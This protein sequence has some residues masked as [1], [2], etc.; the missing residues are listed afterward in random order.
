MSYNS[1]NIGCID[2]FSN[3]KTPTHESK[4]ACEKKKIICA[5]WGVYLLFRRSLKNKIDPIVLVHEL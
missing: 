5:I 4:L 2:N 3:M 1:L